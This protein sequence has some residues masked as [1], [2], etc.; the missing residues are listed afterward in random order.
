MVSILSEKMR[1]FVFVH[2]LFFFSNFLNSFLGGISFFYEEIPS[3]YD[4]QNLD[5]IYER[6]YKV[7]LIV[8]YYGTSFESSCLRRN[9]LELLILPQ[10]DYFRWPREIS[11]GTREETAGVKQQRRETTETR[12]WLTAWSHVVNRWK[13][14]LAPFE[15][16]LSEWHSI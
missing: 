4:T 13:Q 2:F 10:N 3:V 12:Y 5:L 8:T 7:G 9:F 1:F 6:K 15:I 16:S 11:N 14:V